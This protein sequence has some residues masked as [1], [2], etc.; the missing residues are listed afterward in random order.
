[1]YSRLLEFER[2]ADELDAAGYVVDNGEKVIRIRAIIDF[3]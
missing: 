1:M 2:I 3:R